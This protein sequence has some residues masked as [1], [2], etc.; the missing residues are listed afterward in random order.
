L[1]W[2]YD[3]EPIEPTFPMEFDPTYAEILIRGMSHIVPALAAY[4][5]RLPRGVVDGGYYTKTR[6]NRFLA[7]PLPVVGFA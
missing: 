4:L 2:T 5:P 6:E 7:G 3:V 1:I